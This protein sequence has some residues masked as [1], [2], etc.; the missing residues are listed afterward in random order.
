MILAMPTAVKICRIRE[1]INHSHNNAAMVDKLGAPL[2]SGYLQG[3]MQQPRHQ[4]HSG[5]Q[6]G[7]LDLQ[8]LT[9]LTQDLMQNCWIPD[10]DS[11]LKIRYL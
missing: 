6:A 9:P 8:F 7:Q 5:C 2:V 3:V 10:R 4:V 11:V 1:W